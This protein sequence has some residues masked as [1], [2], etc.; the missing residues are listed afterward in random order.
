M[1][2]SN[3]FGLFFSRAALPEMLPWT[4]IESFFLTG[5]F[6]N[7]DL[8]DIVTNSATLSN[9]EIFDNKLGTVDN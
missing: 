8:H 1:P 2:L 3:K 6:I 4:V 9:L 7:F 5:S